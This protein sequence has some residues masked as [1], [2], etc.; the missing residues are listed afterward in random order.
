MRLTL[1]GEE[2]VELLLEELEVLVEELEV[3]L[4][5]DELTNRVKVPVLAV[6]LALPW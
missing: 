2:P 1:D 5:V 6:L 4:E 3:L